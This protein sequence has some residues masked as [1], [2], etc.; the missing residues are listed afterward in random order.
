MS[1]F[2]EPQALPDNEKYASMTAEQA[3]RAF[4][5]AC[6]KGDWDEVAKFVSPLTE[7]MKAYLGGLEIVSLGK[8]F[9]S[10]PYR[11]VHPLRN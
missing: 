5:E 2:K 8:A 10:E 4:F 9:T 3:A 7:Q 1:W 6:G 11:Q